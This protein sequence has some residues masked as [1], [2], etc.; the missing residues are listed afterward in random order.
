MSLRLIIISAMSIALGNICFNIGATNLIRE[1]RTWEYVCMRHGH[2]DGIRDYGLYGFENI[3]YHGDTITGDWTLLGYTSIFPD[4]EVE[5]HQ[6]QDDRLFLK[7]IGG[8]VY[9]PFDSEEEPYFDFTVDNGEYVCPM[10]CPKPVESI[11]HTLIEGECCKVFNIKDWAIYEPVFDLSY[12]FIEGIGPGGNHMFG[13]I[14]CPEVSPTTNFDNEHLN[15]V[16]DS[17]HN[18]IYESI[19]EYGNPSPWGSPNWWSTETLRCIE[20]GRQGV[21]ISRSTISYR[22]ATSGVIQVYSTEGTLLATAEGSGYTEIPLVSIPYTG[23]CVV[24]V[25][26]ERSKPKSVL[27]YIK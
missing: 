8:V 24:Q 21:E 9:S 10:W 26:E 1:G 20:A 19:W 27:T 2:P 17:N 3:T 14:G 15:R 22:F 6:I 11:T 5:I 23:L 13:S 16:Y 12:S 18:V 7:E 4:G 25:K